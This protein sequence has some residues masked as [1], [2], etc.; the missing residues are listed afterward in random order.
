MYY[1]KC[2]KCGKY[3]ELK[4]EFQVFCTHCDKKLVNNYADW[5]KRNPESSFDDFKQQIC[6]TTINEP[7]PIKK[8]SNFLKTKGFKISLI[9]VLAITVFA[10]IGHFASQFV[11]SLFNNVKV[12][13]ELTAMA[14]ELNKSCPLTLDSETRLD[15][16]MALPKKTIQYTYT[17]VN[18]DKSSLNVD[19]IKKYMEPRIINNAKTSP[20]MLEL[21]NRKVTINYYYKDKT[22]AHVLTI[23]V[24]PEQYLQ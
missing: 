12:D 15:N 20:D 7:P 9:V 11:I 10:V 2:S 3:N 16:V 22:G 4:G 14:N 21:R 17:L 13:T 24:K 5:S 1:L 19:E 23:I 18:A 8:S 6:T